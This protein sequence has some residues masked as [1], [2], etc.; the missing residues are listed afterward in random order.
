MFGI[1]RSP[2]TVLFGPGQRFALP[3]TVLQFGRQA[4]ICTD[5]RLA[6]DPIFTDL[7]R[8]LQQAGIELQIYDGVLPD[9]PED[10]ILACAGLM[11]ESKANCVVGIG[12]GSCM[13]VAKLAALLVAHEGVLSDYY[14]SLKVPGPTVP[15]VAVP[16]TSGTGSE[17]SPAAVMT[18]RNEATKN[19]ILSPYLIPHTAICDP[20][21]TV[22]C[23]PGLTAHAGA[24]A[25]THAIEC[26]CAA[27]RPATSTLST[28]HVFLG[29][30]EFSDNY[31]LAAIRL[32]NRSLEG[33][34]ED[35]SN[36][37]TRE[38]VMMGA[39]FA[40]HALA[41]AGTAAAHALQY[42]VGAVTRTAHGLGVAA[43]LP[44][45]MQFNRPSSLDDFLSMAQQMGI[46]SRETDAQTADA[47]IERVATLFASIG[48]PR[49]LQ[50]MLFPLD[51]LDWAAEQAFGFSRM[52]DNNPRKL[53]I[54]SL[55]RILSAAYSGNRAELSH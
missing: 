53:S 2:R 7:M 13:D 25:L 1:L 5:S 14:G 21:L 3:D 39:L 44:Y 30:N 11:R 54:E 52:V 45:V 37:K 18:G 40:G 26:L 33:A 29:K 47:V 17:V 38:D 27:R 8:T 43:L 51:R 22:T 10:C 15:V 41:C 55:K 36:L 46:A 6:A 31:A 19:G 16:T 48:I 12:G 32:L 9:A 4:T 50:Q 20:E 23:P 34:V 28:T 35:G 42:P 49:T 24:D